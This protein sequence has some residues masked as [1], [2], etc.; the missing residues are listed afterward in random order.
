MSLEKC[1][2][3]KKPLGGKGTRAGMSLAYSGNCV[4]EEVTIGA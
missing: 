3:K 1:Q 4:G 2:W